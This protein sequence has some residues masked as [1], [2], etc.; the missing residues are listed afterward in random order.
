MP[1]PKPSHLPGS[2]HQSPSFFESAE[3]DPRQ[4]DVSENTLASLRSKLRELTNPVR[5]TPKSSP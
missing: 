2:Q 3:A 1:Q 5:Q 4:N